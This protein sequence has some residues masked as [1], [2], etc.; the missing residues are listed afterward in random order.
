MSKINS[1][2]SGAVSGGAAGGPWG[3]LA[4]GAAGFLLGSNDDSKSYYDEMLK[5]AQGIPLPVLQ[6]MNP[7]LYKQI[8]SLNPEMDQS[9]QLG[10]SATEGISLDP[11]Y[12]QAQM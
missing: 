10:P 11:K 1:G 6:K 8:I 12:K 2:I 7:E 3:A 4:G 5:Q 9:V